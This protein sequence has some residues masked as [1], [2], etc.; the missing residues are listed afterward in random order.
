MSGDGY[1][2]KDFA[3]FG[4]PPPCFEGNAPPAGR[5]TAPRPYRRAPRGSMVK[6]L[7]FIYLSAANGEGT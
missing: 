2:A 1:G 3:H 5:L 7:K 4:V 6:S